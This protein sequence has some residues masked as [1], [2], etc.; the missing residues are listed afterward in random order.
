MHRNGGRVPTRSERRQGPQRPREL[1]QI[2][3]SFPCPCVDEPFSVPGAPKDFFLEERKTMKFQLRSFKLPCRFAILA[4][5]GHTRGL[6]LV[7]AHRTPYPPRITPSTIP[8]LH[9]SESNLL[10]TWD[11][12][13]GMTLDWAKLDF[14][15]S[16]IYSGR[17]RHRRM[18]INS[19]E[20]SSGRF[21]KGINKPDVIQ[22]SNRPQ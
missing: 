19:S 20:S 13:A 7:S 21:A 9:T 8:S 16:C 4:F 10:R 22:V 11:S 6:V 18:F 15:Y 5:H 12:I 2:V 17:L 1:S 3:R 14:I